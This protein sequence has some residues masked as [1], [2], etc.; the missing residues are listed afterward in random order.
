LGVVRNNRVEF[1]GEA[2]LGIDP[3]REA[4]VVDYHG[5]DESGHRLVGGWFHFVGRIEDGPDTAFAWFSERFTSGFMLGFTRTAVVVEDAFHGL[6]IAQL[7]FF[8]TIPWVLD[9]PNPD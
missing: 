8:A 4:E 9:E 5:K 3:C 2:R 1:E 6:A 7:E